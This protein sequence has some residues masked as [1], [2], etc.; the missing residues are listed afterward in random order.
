MP[1]QDDKK[2]IEIQTFGTHLERFVDSIDIVNAKTFDDLM[3][4]IGKYVYKEL[5]LNYFEL[6]TPT[7]V[8]YKD[9]LRAF[10]VYMNGLPPKDKPNYNTSLFTYVKGRKKYKTQSALAYHRK[11]NL[12]IVSKSQQT[13]K[14]EIENG[15]ED[16]WP[17]NDKSIIL[18]QYKPPDE[19]TAK[20]SI[21]M[22]L[23]SKGNEPIGVVDFEGEYYIKPTRPAIEEL[24]RLAR[25]ISKLL[26]LKDVRETQTANTEW[27]IKGLKSIL[28]SGTLPRLGKPQLFLAYAERA[29][30]DVMD[31]IHKVLKKFSEKIHVIDW[32]ENNRQGNIDIWT[33]KEIAH[34]RFGLCYFSEPT[35]QDSYEYIDN[36]NVLFEAGM[37]HSNTSLGNEEHC[38]WIPVREAA[39]LQK[40]PFDLDHL[41]IIYINR[42]KKDKNVIVDQ[43]KLEKTLHDLIEELVEPITIK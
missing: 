14:S 17:N 34:S 19:L 1:E 39:S 41:K 38:S 5:G 10:Y 16:L 12:W 42:K 2:I 40:T 23:C 15:I 13:L 8:D 29:E 26:Y 7:K 35:Q 3:P 21:L 4:Q 24:T 27:A 33:L 6:A 31:L 43:V 37:L 18:P 11:R 20:I 9:G 32:K 22:P 36:P 25:G 30:P 28:E